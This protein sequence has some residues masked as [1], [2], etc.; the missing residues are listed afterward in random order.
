MVEMRKIYFWL[1]PSTRGG[2]YHLEYLSR[3]LKGMCKVFQAEIRKVKE[4]T[5]N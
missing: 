3:D 1:R 2:S 5:N 4:V